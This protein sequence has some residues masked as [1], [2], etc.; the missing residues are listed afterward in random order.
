MKLRILMVED[1]PED[2]ALIERALVRG[3]HE[4]TCVRVM[5]ASE[6]HAQLDRGGWDIIISDYHLPQFS[7]SSALAVIQE[8]KLDIPFIIV[9][10]TVGEETAVTAMKSGAQDYVMKSNLIRLAATVE[11]EVKE[12]ELRRERVGL[13]QQVRQAQKM[14]AVGQLA[15]GVAHDFNNLL[16]AI[17][18]FSRLVYDDLGTNHPSRDDLH[19]IIECAERAAALTRQLLAFSRRQVFEPRILDLNSVV[20]NADKM[21]RRLIGESVNFEVV[22]AA[23]LWKIWADHG[24]VEQVILNLV[25][26]ARDAMPKGGKLRVETSNVT[27]D[28]PLSGGRLASPPGN[29]VMLSVSDSGIGMNEDVQARIFEPFFTTKEVGKGT[30]LGLATV[31]GIVKQ[32]NGDIAVSSRIGG[33]TIF[34]VLFPKSDSVEEIEAPV[35]IKT[36]SLGKSESILVVEDEDAVRA[37]ARRVLSAAGYVVLEAARPQ[38]AIDLVAHRRVPLNLVLANT[39][40]PEMN[41][42]ELAERLREIQPGLSVLLMSGYGLGAGGIPYLQ[43]PF[44]PEVLIHQVR[45]VLDM[46]RDT[47][48]LRT[49]EAKPI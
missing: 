30:G 26:N 36:L 22:G 4:V 21:L 40:L 20:T 41:G 13:E 24:H 34:R 48:D 47:A 37:V 7:A 16:T 1:S 42:R 45:A 12:A 14:E 17:L 2:A 18:S 9:S 5:S 29:Y 11:R 10:G 27:L 28:Q 46:P 31:Y 35:P 19:E 23:G 49:R 6:M 33:G 25:L 43:K 44:T 3:G 38:E 32:S 8:R 15:G 39:A